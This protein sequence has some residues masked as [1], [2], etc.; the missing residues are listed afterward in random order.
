VSGEN[1]VMRSLMIV[2][3][4]R[5]YSGNQ[6]EKNGMGVACSMYGERFWWENLTE[7]YHLGNPGLDGRI[8]LRWIIRK[9]DG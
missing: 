9:W 3:L 2:L 1:Y 8:I 7:R 6:I 5:Y 4:T